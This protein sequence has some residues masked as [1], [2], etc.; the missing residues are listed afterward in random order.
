MIQKKDRPV[1]VLISC[2]EYE[3]LMALE[4]NY[5]LEQAKQ[6]EKSG[7]EDYFRADIGEHRVIYKFDATTLYVVSRSARRFPMGRQVVKPCLSALY[8]SLPSTALL[9]AADLRSVAPASAVRRVTALHDAGRH[10]ALQMAMLLLP[11]LSTV[12]YT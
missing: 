12:L 1:A 4:N 6:A 8:P 3:R 2:A 10:Q 9:G 7:Y 5:W 11:R